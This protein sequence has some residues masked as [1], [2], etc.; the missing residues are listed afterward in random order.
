MMPPEYVMPEPM[1]QD[2]SIRL[3]RS[4]YHQASEQVVTNSQHKH[5]RKSRYRVSCLHHMHTHTRPRLMRRQDCRL[6]VH[7]DVFVLHFTLY[8][9][10]I[11]SHKSTLQMLCAS[12]DDVVVRVRDNFAP[13]HRG[14]ASPSTPSRRRSRKDTT[15]CARVG[16]S[17]RNV[18]HTL[19]HTRAHRTQLTHTKQHTCTHY[20]ICTRR[21]MHAQ[22]SFTFLFVIV[23]IRRLRRFY[24]EQ[25]CQVLECP[26]RRTWKNNVLPK[27]SLENA[28]Q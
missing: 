1:P 15:T 14:S 28:L 3:Q 8:M 11:H 19:A 2:E 17:D 12:A 13:L 6:G 16:S 18:S 4:A 27:L 21:S 9:L 5:N 10:K 23:A 7:L 26:R 24:A 20:A 25:H 22:F